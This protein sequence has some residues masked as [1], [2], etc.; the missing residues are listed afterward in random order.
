MR[1]AVRFLG[2][3]FG[4]FWLA[5]PVKAEIL[6]E[7]TL[8]KNTLVANTLAAADYAKAPFGSVLFVRHA[9]APGTGDPR[10]FTIDECATQRNLDAVGRRQAVELGAQLRG[11]GLSFARVYSSQWCRCRETA[12]LMQMGPV[13]DL[14]YLN[15]FYQGIVPRGPTLAGLR[16]V[17]DALPDD[18]GITLMVTHFVTISA[19][20]G[21]SVPS[22]GG[23]AY[24]PIS[25]KAVKITF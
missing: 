7:N 18:G 10:H 21:I 11:L 4:I 15:S 3:A 16:S 2:L 14:A 8:V 24:D 25:G 22:G 19:I 23:V 17:L 5:L 12:E 20:T 13:A 9:L 6:V 1:W